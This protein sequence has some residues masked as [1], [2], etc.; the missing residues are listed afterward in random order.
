MIYEMIYLIIAASLAQPQEPKDG[1]L[2]AP[3]INFNSLVQYA[4]ASAFLVYKGE[5]E[6]QSESA[7][8]K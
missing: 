2:A 1:P 6:F 8:K 7:L 5:S 4:N 3:I